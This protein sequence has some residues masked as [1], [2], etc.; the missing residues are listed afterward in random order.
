M[1]FST[2]F[3]CSSHCSDVVKRYYLIYPQ[4]FRIFTIWISN[5]LTSRHGPVAQWIEHCSDVSRGCGFESHQ[6]HASQKWDPAYVVGSHFLLLWV[7][8]ILPMWSQRPR[9]AF[10]Q[11]SARDVACPLNGAR[12]GRAI[13]KTLN[14]VPKSARPAISSLFAK[15]PFLL[16]FDHYEF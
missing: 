9:T 11:R 15:T 14:T 7:T 6:G 1:D 4:G 10:H 13:G 5:S 3:T 16:A 8:T 2:G 12:N